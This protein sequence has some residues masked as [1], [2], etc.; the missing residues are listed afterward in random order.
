MEAIVSFFYEFCKRVHIC[1]LVFITMMKVR[2]FTSIETFV[3]LSKLWKL[4]IHFTVNAIDL[5][6]DFVVLLNRFGYTPVEENYEIL[7]CYCIFFIF[8]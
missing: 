4:K 6:K 1:V 5:P 8:Q 3:K 2:L 7:V